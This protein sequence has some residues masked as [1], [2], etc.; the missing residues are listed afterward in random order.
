MG[1]RKEQTLRQSWLTVA[2]LDAHDEMFNLRR[3]T[4]D[5]G[6]DTETLERGTTNDIIEF[7][8]NVKIGYLES[9]QSCWRRRR[10][11]PC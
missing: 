2:G 6:D 9:P 3:G 11:S 7:S 4:E 10:S 8:R 1:Q 5:W